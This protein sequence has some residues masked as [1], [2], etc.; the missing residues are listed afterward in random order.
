MQF[1]FYGLILRYTLC[2]LDYIFRLK[3]MRYVLCVMCYVQTL[4]C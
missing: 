1:I 3:I 2:N 4:L